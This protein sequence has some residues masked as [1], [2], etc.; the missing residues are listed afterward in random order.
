M[1]K[2][3][4]QSCLLITVICMLLFSTSFKEKKY[5]Y[6]NTF[7]QKPLNSLTINGG[8]YNGG[9]T[10]TLSND[11][12]NAFGLLADG[13]ITAT[14]KDVV[15]SGNDKNEITINMD[16]PAKAPAAYSLPD[17]NG[18]NEATIEISHYQNDQLIITHDFTVKKGTL[19]ITSID[20]KFAIG[21]FDFTSTDT[22]LTK[23][24]VDYHIKGNFKVALMSL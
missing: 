6:N 19:K 11:K 15:V 17:D 23:T 4:Q 14:V 18:D 1:K 5:L 13:R 16:F 10:Y 9:V 20:K 3:S 2:K 7:I 21:S 22:D 8:E 12:K 24:E